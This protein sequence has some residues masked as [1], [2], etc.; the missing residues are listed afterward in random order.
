M[1]LNQFNIYIYIYIYIYTDEH[2][3]MPLST[4]SHT[5]SK[6]LLFFLVNVNNLHLL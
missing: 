1:V 3:H 4:R 6:A 5:C 2:A